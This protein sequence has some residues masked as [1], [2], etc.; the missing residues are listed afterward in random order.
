MESL[1]I[2]QFKRFPKI[3]AKGEPYTLTM[4]VDGKNRKL[5]TFDNTD[6]WKNGDVVEMEVIEKPGFDKKGNAVVYFN[7]KYSSK[8]QLP[9]QSSPAVVSPLAQAYTFAIGVAPILYKDKK[10]P[11]LAEF[12]ELVN[13]IKSFLEAKPAAQPAVPEVSLDEET[14]DTPVIKTA[15]QPVAPAFDEDESEDETPF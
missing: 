5:S 13:E 2:T 6:N 12:H 10:A 15:K 11:K 8:K 1:K 4:F 14:P 7:A 9:I 3:N